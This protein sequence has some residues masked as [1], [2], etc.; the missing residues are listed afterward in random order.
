M[1][2]KESAANA[3]TVVQ[4]VPALRA[5]STVLPPG[6]R[7]ANYVIKTLLGEGGMGQVYVAEQLQPV[8]REVALKLLREQLS[9]TLARAYFEV[10]RQALAQMQHA[11]IAQVFDAGST[12]TEQAYIAMEYIRGEPITRYCQEHQLGRRERLRLFQRVCN[13]VQHAHQKGVIHRDLKPDNVLVRSEDGMAQP[14]IIDF[15]IAIGSQGAAEGLRERAGT[16]T[17]MSPEQA[18]S[19]PRDIDTRSDV[20]SL[21]VMLFEVLTDNDAAQFTSHPFKS[22]A[23]LRSTLPRADNMDGD[24]GQAPPSPL[25]AARQLPVELRAIVHKALQPDRAQRYDS[26]AALAEDIER[27]LERRPILA[28]T[29]SHGYQARKF[30]S[31]H[32]LGLTVSSLMVAA[33]AVGIVLALQGQRRAEAAA[34]QAQIEAAKAQQVSAFVSDMLSG[35]NPTFAKGKDTT[36]MRMVLDR[37]AKRAGSELASAPDVLASIEHTI[38]AAYRALGMYDLALDHAQAAVAAARAADL[39]KLKQAQMVISEGVILA[40]AHVPTDQYLAKVKEA[41]ALLVGVPRDSIAGLAVQHQIA[42]LEW[43]AGLL[44]TAEKRLKPALALQR[45][46]LPPDDPDLKG[47]EALMASIYSDKG[48]YAAAELI[49]RELLVHDRRIYGNRDATTIDDANELAIVLMRQKKFADGEKLLREYL[50]I[51][52]EI[53]GKDHPVAMRLYSNL[54]GAIRQQGRNEEARPYYKHTLEWSLERFGPDSLTAVQGEANLAFLLRD[55][56]Q[57]AEAETHARLAVAHLDTALG[58]DNGA[59]GQMLDLLGTIL[60]KERRYADA[61]AA[62]DRAWKVYLESAGF[63]ANHPLA[64]ETVQHQVELYK[65]W[66]KPAEEAMWAARLSKVDSTHE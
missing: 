66:E 62:Y 38:A 24:G 3:P 25:A 29:Q 21:G 42:R 23:D 40:Y 11:A 58:P 9:S 27:Y 34:R 14:K 53:F 12:D 28:M 18:A 46:L 1:A 10:E 4:G 57:L 47:S 56:G 7:V 51:A 41:E 60:F 65:A 52:N 13:G 2:D 44:D 17:Y 33:L 6:S 30:I 55:A 26:A 39:P 49:Q 8:Q 50:P 16:V 43:L 15:G 63:G 61:A 32:R 54:G 64:Q 22:G 19:Q 59:R 35:I 5:D 45:Q 20:Y 48:D 31:R 36:L 37:A